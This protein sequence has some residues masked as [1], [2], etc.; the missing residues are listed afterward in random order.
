[1]PCFLPA[2]HGAT[3]EVASGTPMYATPALSSVFRTIRVKGRI[4]AGDSDKLKGLLVGLKVSTPPR[5][6]GSIVVE[7]SGD[8]SDLAEGIKVGDLIR[9]FRVSTVVRKGDS[10]LG[11]CFVAFVGGSAREPSFGPQRPSRYIEIGGTAGIPNFYAPPSQ[12]TQPARYPVDQLLAYASRMGIEKGLR[13]RLLGEAPD[14]ILYMSSVEGF[15]ALNACPIGLGLP[16]TSPGVQA[17]NVCVHST[18]SL[19]RRLPLRTTAISAAEARL[20]LLKYVKMHIWWL[21]VVGPR[22]I[23]STPTLPPLK[24]ELAEQL[25]SDRFAENEESAMELYADLRAAGMPLPE[26]LDATFEVSGYNPTNDKITCIVSLSAD[27]ADRYD[28]VI[29]GPEGMRP[30]SQLAPRYCRSLF[31]YDMNDAVNPR[32]N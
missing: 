1:M 2:G 32:P 19:D 8:G 28:L 26:L 20:S 22:L 4:E 21:G 31:R 7:L 11:A 27:D 6:D 25:K 17:A 12:R 30:A 29:Q 15:L 9:E 18:R 23:M 16:S 5:P 24:S 10:C 3:I 13:A 14:K